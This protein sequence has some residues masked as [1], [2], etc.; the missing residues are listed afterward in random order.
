VQVDTIGGQGFTQSLAAGNSIVLF[1]PA[2]F[3]PVRTADESGSITVPVQGRRQHTDL[4][5]ATHPVD[6]TFSLIFD[7]SLD[8]SEASQIGRSFADNILCLATLESADAANAFAEC[9]N[10]AIDIIKQ[11]HYF[12][13]EYPFPLTDWE[14]GGWTASTLVGPYTVNTTKCDGDGGVWPLD[15]EADLDGA[16]YN[17]TILAELDPE[18]GEGAYTLVGQAVGGGFTVPVTGTGTMRFVRDGP[19]LA[20]LEVT[21]AQFGPRDA[22]GNLEGVATIALTPFYGCD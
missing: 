3:H 18:T 19:D 9:Q 13:G 10:A 16:H 8:P 1:G 5:E 20:H 7:A 14:L 12:V 15:L 6:K 2:T 22:G 4:S 11:F 21:G 17:A